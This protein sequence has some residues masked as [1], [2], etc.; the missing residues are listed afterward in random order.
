[1]SQDA[2]GKSEPQPIDVPAVVVQTMD[3]FAALAWQK[4]GLQPDMGTGKTE[5]DLKQARLAIDA[6]AALAG[7]IEPELED[8]ADKRNVHNIVRD[9][10]INFVEKSG[11]KP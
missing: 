6:T 7:V 5:M 11:A 9:L 4:L 2:G 10:R 1:M 8:E 3:F